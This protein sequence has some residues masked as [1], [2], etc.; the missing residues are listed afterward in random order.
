[1]VATL[2]GTL[3]G[4]HLA[5]RHYGLIDRWQGFDAEIDWLWRMLK[6]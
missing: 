6:R 5:R 4:V 1:M 2:V 3:L